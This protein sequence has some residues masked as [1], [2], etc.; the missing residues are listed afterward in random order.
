MSMQHVIVLDVVQ[1]NGGSRVGRRC[2]ED[3]GSG[4]FNRCMLGFSVDRGYELIE[5]TSRREVFSRRSRT[6]FRHVHMIAIKV[7]AKRIG[8]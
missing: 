4:Y 3:R 7:P 1:E 6:P 2:Q 8:T 5:R